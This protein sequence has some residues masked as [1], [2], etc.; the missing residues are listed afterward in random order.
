[1]HLSGEQQIRIFKGTETLPQ[2]PFLS[3]PL[4]KRRIVLHQ[5]GKTVAYEFSHLIEFKGI[6]LLLLG[7]GETEKK[8]KRDF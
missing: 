2:G 7:S 3:L 6:L 8:R 4:R 5:L 1:M